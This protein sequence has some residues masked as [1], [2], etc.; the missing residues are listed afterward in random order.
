MTAQIKQISRPQVV[1]Q[2][3]I[4]SMR[5]ILEMAEKGEVTGIVMVA[6]LV[7]TGEYFRASSF[8]RGWSMIGALEHAKDSVLGALRK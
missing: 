4:D 7:D 6:D 2:D 5:E 1:D 8:D 3:T